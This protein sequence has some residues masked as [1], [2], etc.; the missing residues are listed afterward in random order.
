MPAAKGGIYG[1]LRVL[2]GTYRNIERY[3]A[4]E[5]NNLS[6]KYDLG[7]NDHRTRVGNNHCPDERVYRTQLIKY[8]KFSLIMMYYT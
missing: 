8:Y 7:K 5:Y 1:F 2:F 6:M 4:E 3:L